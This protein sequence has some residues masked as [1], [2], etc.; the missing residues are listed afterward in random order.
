M[1]HATGGLRFVAV[2]PHV[3]RLIHPLL[4]LPVYTRE[5]STTQGN[6]RLI[7]RGTV[8]SLE[9][10]D[11]GVFASLV[12]FPLFLYSKDS[13]DIAYALL[14]ARSL[15]TNCDVSNFSV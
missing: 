2:V 11:D 12:I 14:H 9:L 4:I 7:D 6:Q 10:A 3:Y 13:N 8:P 5:Y 15:E 1:I